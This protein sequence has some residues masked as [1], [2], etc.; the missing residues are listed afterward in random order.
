MDIFSLKY[1]IREE[2]QFQLKE[3]SI[4]R[5][6]LTKHANNRK[7]TDAVKNSKWKLNGLH[8]HIFSSA[9]LVVFFFFANGLDTPDIDVY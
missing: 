5:L 3:F 8:P 9:N 7:V 4:K 2:V 1:K 6:C